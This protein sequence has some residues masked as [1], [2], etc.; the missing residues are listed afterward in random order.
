[1]IPYTIWKTQKQQTLIHLHGNR[2]PSTAYFVYLSHRRSL[3]AGAAWLIGSF[4]TARG[5]P[6]RPRD[7]LTG[8]A[9]TTLM[10]EWMSSAFL[11][12]DP[13]SRAGRIYRGSMIHEGWVPIIMSSFLL[14]SM[15]LLVARPYAVHEV[16]L[17]WIKCYSKWINSNCFE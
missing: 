8:A 17:S 9:H 15:G 2:T 4:H 7:P 10:V 6:R 16:L 5:R 3:V 11:L 13:L 1:M 14:G 12:S